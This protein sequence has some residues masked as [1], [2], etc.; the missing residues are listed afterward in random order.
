[1]QNQ[2][3]NASKSVLI[4]FVLCLLNSTPFSSHFRVRCPLLLFLLFSI[5]FPCSFRLLFL[6]FSHSANEPIQS[7]IPTHTQASSSS[8][9]PSGRRS[10]SLLYHKYGGLDTKD[11]PFSPSRSDLRGIGGPGLITFRGRRFVRSQCC[12]S[13]VL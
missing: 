9:L 12:A 4:L 2:H 7:P 10:N 5:H 6:S 13:S 1:M 3:P 11:L 8:F